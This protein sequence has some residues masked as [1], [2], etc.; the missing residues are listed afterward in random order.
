MALGFS[1]YDLIAVTGTGG[2]VFPADH[3]SF[4]QD[5]MPL[6]GGDPST[7]QSSLEVQV[8]SIA[9]GPRTPFLVLRPGPAGGLVGA[10]FA[11]YGR[12]RVHGIRSIDHCTNCTTEDLSFAGGTFWRV[13]AELGPMMSGVRN[14][15]LVLSVAYQRYAAVTGLTQELRLGFT[16]WLL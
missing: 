10:L 7:A 15:G 13:G 4:S 16:W 6:G 1:I 3:A 2:A 5:V 8:Y 14:G 11:D 12:A 9:V